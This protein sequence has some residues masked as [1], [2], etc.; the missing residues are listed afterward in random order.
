MAQ[1]A[2][3]LTRAVVYCARSALWQ[4]RPSD[5]WRNGP[6]L[7]QWVHAQTTVET[8]T[9]MR[10]ILGRSLSVDGAPQR[11]LSEVTFGASADTLTRAV[12]YCAGVHIGM[13]VPGMLGAMGHV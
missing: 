10:A 2:D 12:V 11:S 6:C 1:A 7:V 3:M 13:G 9:T 8:V 5:A 4:G